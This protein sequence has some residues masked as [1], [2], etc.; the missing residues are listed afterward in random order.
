MNHII[1]S[2]NT[3]VYDIHIKSRETN[4]WVKKVKNLLNGQGHSYI[5]ININSIIKL[6]LNTIKQRIQINFCK[7]KMHVCVC[8][9]V[10]VCGGGG[11]KRNHPV[12]PSVHVPCKHNSS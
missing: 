6:N 10:C 4:P 1:S 12:R 5:I 11:V 2:K 9:C 8:V 3:L 7:H